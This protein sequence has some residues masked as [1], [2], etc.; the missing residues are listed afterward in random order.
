[1]IPGW[2]KP[3]KNSDYATHGGHGVVDMNTVLEFSLNTG[4]IF[5][6]EKLGTE[7]FTEYVKRFGFGEKTG[8]ELET[9]GVSNINNLLR[10][11]IRPIE[12]ATA[13]FGQGIT[14]TPL[15]MITSY[16][17]IVNG[18]W[19]VKP[20]VVEEI[21]APDGSVSR[22]QPQK[23]RRVISERTALLVSGMMVNVVDRG[24]STRAQVKGYYVGGK[25]GTAQVAGRGGYSD[26]TIHTFVGFAPAE[27]PEFVMLVRF[28][29]VKSVRFADSSAAPLFSELSE[30][31]LNYYQVEKER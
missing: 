18:G 5:V 29:N 16:A 10:K 28:D 24:H 17:A 12:A 3:I 19:L 20:Y 13:S 9:E 1:M 6:E 21:V 30:H 22:T 14:A 15:Q 7:K 23:L 2:D 26:Q 11:K 25:T 27:E 8:I 4:T 31:I